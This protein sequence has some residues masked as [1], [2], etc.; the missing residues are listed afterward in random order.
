[1]KKYLAFIALFLVLASCGPKRV[2][3]AKYD[4]G[5]PRV[6]KYYDKVDGKE[7]LV[8][9]EV[10]YENKVKKMEGE[11]SNDQRTGKW[12]AWY[13]NGKLWSTGE[14]KDGKRNGP[15]M[16]YHENGNKYIESVYANDEKT[17]K[18]K[19]YDTTG[20]VVKEVDFDMLNQKKLNDSIK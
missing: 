15:G 6:V 1:M 20:K 12:S 10:F 16:V 19:F 3:E 17:G 11:Y 2:V 14:Y 7:K 5:N 9:E 4:N 13:E 8:K 18:W